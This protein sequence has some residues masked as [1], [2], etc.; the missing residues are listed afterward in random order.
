MKKPAEK[1]CQ[2]CRDPFTPKPQAA[3]V[4]KYCDKKECQQ[5]RQKKKY[6]RWIAKPEK[7]AARREYYRTWAN[8]NPDYWKQR[9]VNDPDYAEHD[10]K[11]RAAS[12]QR[13]RC[14]AKQTDWRKIAVERLDAIETMDGPVCSAKQTDLSRRMGAMLGYLRWTV[15]AG[16][17]AKQTGIAWLGGTA[18]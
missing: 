1:C 8:D 13:T 6:R 12:L 7:A 10:D 9:R 14:S 2:N 16:M 15:E 3:K 11:R 18:E 5:V 17:S 4:Q